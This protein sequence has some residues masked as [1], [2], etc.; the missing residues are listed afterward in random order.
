MPHADRRRRHVSTARTRS[1]SRRRPRCEEIHADA[2]L[3]ATGS[4]P[5]IP[6]GARP[7]ASA[8][9]RPRAVLPAAGPSASTSIV[10]GS[11]VTGVEFVHMFSTLGSKV[12]LAREPPAGAAQQGPRGR[13]RARGGLPASGRLAAEGCPGRSASTAPTTACVVRCDDG[14]VVRRLATRCWPSVRCPTPT[15]SGSRRPASRSTAAATSRS[16]TTASPTSPHIYA[17]G[18]VSGKLP[19]SSVAAMQGRKVAEHVMGLHT[20]EHRHLDYDKAASAIFTEPE[21]ADVGLAEAEAFAMGRK[22]RV[23]KV[24]FSAAPKALI[25]NDPRGFVKILSDPATGVVLGGSIV[26]RHAAELISV[27]ALGGHGQPQGHR[28]R[29]EPARAPGAG[30][31]ARRRRRLTRPAVTRVDHGQSAEARTVPP[32]SR[33]RPE[34]RPVPPVGQCDRRRP[35]GSSRR[36]PPGGPSPGPPKSTTGALC[37]RSRFGGDSG[38]MHWAAERGM[39]GSG[40]TPASAVAREAGGLPSARS[41]VSRSWVSAWRPHCL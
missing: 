20:L 13:R 4:R 23:T 31:G 24:P 35:S 6:S 29:R 16:T 25:N 19:L 10:I 5:R 7:T 26:G 28:H 33:A 18:D 9:S 34:R 36:P 14:R 2:V 39:A 3:I 27:I 11:G 17:A 30:R 8:S 38:A 37:G 22:I 12:S 15:A 1:W 41:G 21:I 32:S 40:E